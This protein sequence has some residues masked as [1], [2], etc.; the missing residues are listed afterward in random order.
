[1]YN[2]KVVAFAGVTAI[3]RGAKVPCNFLVTTCIL[4]LEHVANQGVAK[5]P[6]PHCCVVQEYS[7]P[8]GRTSIVAPFCKQQREQVLNC[9]TETAL[10]V[11]CL[12]HKS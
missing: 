4:Y 3:C 9:L 6:P 2:T 10:P 1:M 5:P 12:S 8:K 7:M 11:Y